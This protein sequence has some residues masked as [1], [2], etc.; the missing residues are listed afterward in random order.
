MPVQVLASHAFDGLLLSRGG[1]IRCRAAGETLSMR[2]HANNSRPPEPHTHTHFGDFA[3]TQLRSFLLISLQLRLQ[4]PKERSQIA[5]ARLLDRTAGA[6]VACS[7]HPA[8]RRES[9]FYGR[10]LQAGEA[11]PSV[12]SLI[13][14]YPSGFIVYSPPPGSRVLPNTSRAPSADQSGV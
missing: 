7:Q 13:T 3:F 4:Y 2:Q 10:G 9:L 12:V 11:P 6:S 1:E 14:S 8:P 5:D